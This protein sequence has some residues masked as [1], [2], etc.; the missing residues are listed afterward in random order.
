MLRWTARR[1]A[2]GASALR[3]IVKGTTTDPSVYAHYFGA[4]SHG[5]LHPAGDTADHV[6]SPLLSGDPWNKSIMTSP[7]SAPLL[8]AG[9]SVS[10]PPEAARVSLV[11]G[12]VL[13]RGTRTCGPWEARWAVCCRGGFVGTLGPGMGAE[14]PPQREP[15]CVFFQKGSSRPPCGVAPRRTP[16]VAVCT[17]PF[18]RRTRR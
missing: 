9:S 12:R 18:S 11:L 6:I 16:H 8:S 13:R 1:L 17:R 3:G 7:P 10:V 5:R 2:H 15:A 14:R 4:D